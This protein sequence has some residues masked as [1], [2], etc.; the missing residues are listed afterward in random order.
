MVAAVSFAACS[1]GEET[2][3]PKRLPT[4]AVEVTI[5]PTLQ[6]AA[7]PAAT[8]DV[9]VIDRVKAD[10]AARLQLKAADITVS[11][12]SAVMWPDGCLGLGGPGVVC[13]QALVPGWLAILGAPDGR[14]FRYRG[15][16]DRFAAEP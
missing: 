8:P 9:T 10:L 15:A 12:L 11:S 1:T 3:G 14:K 5:P 16:G 13:T 4:L 6:P 7:P 2:P